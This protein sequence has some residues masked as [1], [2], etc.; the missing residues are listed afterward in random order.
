MASANARRLRLKG[1]KDGGATAPGEGKRRTK[2]CHP[3]TRLDTPFAPVRFPP[4]SLLGGDRP[5][6]R[7]STSPLTGSA[8]QVA[9]EPAGWL[10]VTRGLVGLAKT[11]PLKRACMKN[12]LHF[13][14]AG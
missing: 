2:S 8:E 13:G 14:E 1:G 11:D 7:P 12:A 4:K 6:C 5:A 3:W 10:G 9:A